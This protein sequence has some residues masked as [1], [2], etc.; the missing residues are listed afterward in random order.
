V[1]VG[2]Y[3]VELAVERDGLVEA[4]VSAST[5][6]PLHDG[7]QVV[8]Y[9]QPQPR[10]PIRLAYSTE[11][12]RFLGQAAAGARLESGAAHVELTVNGQTLTG[13]GEHVVARTRAERG[14][15]LLS[16][17]SYAVEFIARS[18]GA[19]SASVYDPGGARLSDPQLALRATLRTRNQRAETVPLRWERAQQLYLGT[20]SS[21]P[22]PLFIE[23]TIDAGGPVK[24]GRHQN[25]AVA[26]T[27]AQ[28]GTLVLAGYYSLELVRSEGLLAAHVYD[29]LA[30]PFPQNYLTLQLAVGAGNGNAALTLKWNPARAAYT[31]PL[32][33]AQN[34]TR[35]FRV[36][37]TVGEH[38]HHGSHAALPAL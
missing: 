19:L 30:R 23:L 4:D 21:T 7:V 1:A 20:V 14:G 36:A 5:G 3:A 32:A 6:R 13:R 2:D 34:L 9:L 15:H 38:I 16:V 35:P 24:R 12:R 8:A 28:G 37:L 11:R 26:P 17:S 29:A 22:E 27:P 33:E 10:A 18:D 31:L 25:V